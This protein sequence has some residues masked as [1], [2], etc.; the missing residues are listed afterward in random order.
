[1]NRREILKAGFAASAVGLAPRLASADVNF[2]PTPK[3]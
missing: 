2:L 1:M 3:G